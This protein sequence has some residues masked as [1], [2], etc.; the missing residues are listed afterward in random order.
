MPSSARLG[1]LAEFGPAP[2]TLQSHDI[3]VLVRMTSAIRAAL[4]Q[5]SNSDECCR[6]RREASAA[7]LGHSTTLE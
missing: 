6:W 5:P 1:V 3:G 7:G 2:T 4:V